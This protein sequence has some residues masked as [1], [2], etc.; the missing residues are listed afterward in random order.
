[1]AHDGAPPRLRTVGVVLAGGTG[2]R[3]GG[4]TP[5]QLLEIAGRPLLVHTLTAFQDSPDVDDVLVVMTPGFCDAVTAL[6]ARFGL[7]KVSAVVEGGATRSA[8]TLH[9]L[10]AL[11]TDECNVLFHDA[12]RPFVTPA[13]IGA[14]VRA[15]RSAEAVVVAVAPTDTLLEVDDDDVVVGVP[16][17]RRLRR[18]QTPQGFRLST[19]RR[20]YDI[21]GADASADAT[22]NC[23]VVRRHL[24]DVTIHVVEGSEANI[25]VTS[26]T[27]LAIAEMLAERRHS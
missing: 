2:S 24:P 5:K 26:T 20:A 14:C 9:A 15:L 13:L 17:R 23:G 19:V 25:K 12:A 8:S 22:D 1:M 3:I 4:A 21:A 18:A 6:V 10:N 16:D 7:S 11:G 27:D